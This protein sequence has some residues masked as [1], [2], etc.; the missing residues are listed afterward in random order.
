MKAGM[1]LRKSRQ[2]AHS[3]GETLDKHREMLHRFAADNAITVVK[4]YE[5]VASGE[6]IFARP[7]MQELLADLD[8]KLFEAVLCMDIDRLGRGD[9]QEQG[10]IMNQ[11]KYS[12]TKIITPREVYNPEDEKDEMFFEFKGII[13]RNELKA[14]K[15][16]MYAGRTRTIEQGGYIAEP[17]FGYRRAWRGKLPTL[18]AEPEQ[19]ETVRL[20][21]DL[22][23]NRNL[24]THAIAQELNRMGLSGRRGAPFSRN[25]VRFILQNRTYTGMVQWDRN[26]HVHT[27]LPGGKNKRI[28]TPPSEWIVAEGAH[29]AI[30]DADLFEKAQQ[31]RQSRAHPP[32][33]TGTIENPFAGLVYC[34][35]CGAALQRQSLRKKY[36]SAR[37]LCPTKGCCRSVLV[38][39]IE[40]AVYQNLEAMLREQAVSLEYQKTD[41]HEID[42]QMIA[43]LEKRYALLKRQE[44][45]LH[46]LL[47]Q[48]VYDSDTFT[49]RK[50]KLASQM[51]SVHSSICEYRNSREHFKAIGYRQEAS[52]KELLK[53][54][55]EC[56]AAQKNAILKAIIHRI[57]YTK[58]KEQRDDDFAIRIEYKYL[59]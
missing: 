51:E 25:T 9:M 20:I 19:A 58:T 13:A 36:E 35:E 17:P 44:E 3:A 42:R 43:G 39:H 4:V 31:I 2:D 54:Y 45:S 46:D 16:R 23:V 15:R 59:L 11:F 52:A 57:E 38:S 14:I 53:K 22:Y 21:F 29:P 50:N 24:G 48:G 32:S 34:S 47:E 5:E 26:K 27:G 33:N 30:I 37:L 40:K 6:S 49:E 56:T 10:F 41:Q 18:A 55:W 1:Y 28:I 12:N 8:K 7:K